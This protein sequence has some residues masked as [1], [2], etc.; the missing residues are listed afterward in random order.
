LG[1]SVFRV[2]G[3]LAGASLS[4]GGQ[5]GIE[6]RCFAYSVVTFS[7][8]PAITTFGGNERMALVADEHRTSV[9]SSRALLGRKSSHSKGSSVD[10]HEE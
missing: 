7:S 4:N 2:W 9:S 5:V 3:P 6:S 8:S 10:H 1:Q